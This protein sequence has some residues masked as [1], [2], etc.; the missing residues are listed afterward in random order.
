MT[1]VSN[2]LLGVLAVAV[3]ALTLFLIPVLLELR[4]TV[5]SLNAV[6]KI[7]EESLAPTMRELR[8]TLVNLDRITSDIN[9]VTDDVRLFSGSLRQVGKD[10]HELREVVGLLGGGL[11][12]KL[13]GLRAGI[14]TGFKFLAHNL[15]K[16]GGTP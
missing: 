6:L 2:V 9:S 8:S 7:T 15:L 13:A 12:A 3:A 16:K 14:G 1:S 5:R 10:L 4:R 11:G